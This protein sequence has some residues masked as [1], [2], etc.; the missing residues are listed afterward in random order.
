MMDTRDRMEE[1]GSQMNG[2][3]EVP[4]DGKSLLGDYITNEELNA[5]TTCN[6]CVEACPVSI[7]PLDIITQMRRYNSMEAANTPS[8][9]ND[10]FNNVENNASPWA[11]PA[12]DR[13]NWA[14]D[15]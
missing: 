2:G 10:M 9:W 4:D 1:L 3:N 13:M 14:D 8:Q 11:Y 12:E 6:A 5:C 15:D 7:N